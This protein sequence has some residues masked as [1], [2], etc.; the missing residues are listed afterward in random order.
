MT[1]FTT[2]S[3]HNT[4]MLSSDAGSLRFPRTVCCSRSS[5][6]TPRSSLLQAKLTGES[7]ASPSV[8]SPTRQARGSSATRTPTTAP[9]TLA[10]LQTSSEVDPFRAMTDLLY[11]NVMGMAFDSDGERIL[12]SIELDDFPQ[13]ELSHGLVRIHLFMARKLIE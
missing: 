11:V 3:Q 6:P 7:R 5:S 8:H 2:R 9:S 12:Y 4:N 13:L 1:K 10:E